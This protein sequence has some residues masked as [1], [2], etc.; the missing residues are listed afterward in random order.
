[1]LA[2]FPVERQLVGTP[3]QVGNGLTYPLDLAKLGI[4]LPRIIGDTYIDR[5][6]HDLRTVFYRLPQ[7]YQQWVPATRVE[8]KDL[9]TGA[10]TYTERPAAWGIY[11][12]DVNPQ[13]NA[14]GDFP[15]ESTFGLNIAHRNGKLGEIYDVINFF[16]LPEGVD[17]KLVPIA[18]LADERP[19]KWLPPAGTVFGEILLVHYQNKIY[20]QEIRTRRLNDDYTTWQVRV[21]RPV[22]NRAEFTALTGIAYEPQKRFMHFR[23]PEEDKVFEVSGTVERLPNVAAEQTIRMLSRPFQDVTDSGWSPAADQDFAILPKDYSL[24]V[25]G[26]P[27][28]KVCASCHNQTGI[29]VNG[30]TPREKLIQSKPLE[31]G[32]IRGSG[33]I[34]TWHPF[35]SESVSKVPNNPPGRAVYY[36]NFDAQNRLIVLLHKGAKTDAQYKLT[37]YVQQALRPWELP[38]RQ[39]LHPTPRAAHSCDCGKDCPCL[40]DSGKCTCGND[41]QCAEEAAPQGWRP[42]F[43][44]RVMLPLSSKGAQQPAPAQKQMNVAGLRWT[45]DQNGRWYWLQDAKGAFIGRFNPE[46]QAY[47]E[48]TGWVSPTSITLGASKQPPIPP[49]AR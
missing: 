2:Q 23:N 41:C 32:N 10:V 7:V 3:E 28:S 14:N 33:G 37:R 21:Y 46:T 16:A 45:L 15:W 17:G 38:E 9:A 18:V 44:S 34:F 1:V 22:Q 24:G 42:L 25:L 36:R 48:V 39:Y 8:Q 27:D 30:L 49:P 35:A 12:T 6:L 19:I 29:G 11:S 26:Q 13:L 47:Q 5:K 31:N 20:I 40:K 43:D 4:V